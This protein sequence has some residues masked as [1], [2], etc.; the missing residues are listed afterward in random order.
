MNKLLCL[1][2]M[3]FNRILF[4]FFYRRAIIYYANILDFSFSLKD[5]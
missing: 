5:Y 1:N 2:M 4:L 3:Y